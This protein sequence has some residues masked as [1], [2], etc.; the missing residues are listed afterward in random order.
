MLGEDSVD[1]AAAAVADTGC[2]YKGEAEAVEDSTVQ[3][4][5]HEHHKWTSHMS[6]TFQDTC[7]RERWHKR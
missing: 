1:A 7:R 6:T 3:H 2:D 4:T 5:L